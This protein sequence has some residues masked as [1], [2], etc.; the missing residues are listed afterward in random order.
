ME[1]TVSTKNKRNHRNASLDRMSKNIT[2]EIQKIN[3]MQ[4]NKKFIPKCIPR[5]T[6]YKL[7]PLPKVNIR[8]NLRK[9]KK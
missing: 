6:G 3:K 2:H 4:G 7:R 8:R 1:M 9:Y 5:G